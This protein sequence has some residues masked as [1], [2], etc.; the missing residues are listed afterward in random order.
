MGTAVDEPALGPHVVPSPDT[1]ADQREHVV[2]HSVHSPYYDD[3]FCTYKVLKSSPVWTSS[4]D[5][6]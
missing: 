4:E 5:R 6:R 1:H 3:C 2:L